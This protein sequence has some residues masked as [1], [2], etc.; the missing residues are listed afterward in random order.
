MKEDSWCGLAIGGATFRV[1]GP[2][3][4]CTVP[5]VDQGSGRRDEAAVGPM[6]S[7][8]AYRSRAGKG[9]LFGAYLSPVSLGVVERGAAARVAYC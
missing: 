8:R 5:D 7:L 1:D 9:V 4:R 6:K 3:P 2:C